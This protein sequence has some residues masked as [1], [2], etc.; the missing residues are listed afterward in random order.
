M[1]N[2]NP[3]KPSLPSFSFRSEIPADPSVWSKCL[4]PPSKNRLTGQGNPPKIP[5]SSRHSKRVFDFFRPVAPGRSLHN[6]PPP[7]AFFDSAFGSGGIVT[8]GLPAGAE[9]L[10]G[11]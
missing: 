1:T 8:N 10:D 6:S 2:S 4:G 9:R 3:Q 11:V 5:L 7:V